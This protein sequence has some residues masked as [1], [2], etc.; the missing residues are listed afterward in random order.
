MQQTFQGGNGELPS[1]LVEL[2]AIAK[3][4]SAVAPPQSISESNA[5]EW[6][7]CQTRF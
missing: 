7:A 1:L 2:S 3:M 4:E 5:V 6:A